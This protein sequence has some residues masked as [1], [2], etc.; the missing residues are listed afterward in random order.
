VDN[1]ELLAL[2]S[3]RR[4]TISAVLVWKLKIARHCRIAAHGGQHNAGLRSCAT[5]FTDARRPSRPFLLPKNRFNSPKDFNQVVFAAFVEEHDHR[6]QQTPFGRS[7]RTQA[8]G[9]IGRRRAV[10]RASG[11]FLLSSGRF[12]VSRVARPLWLTNRADPKP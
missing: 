3:A 5:H 4:S 12:D 1:S 10:E 11:E 6:R 9:P 2:Y 8:A 7:Q